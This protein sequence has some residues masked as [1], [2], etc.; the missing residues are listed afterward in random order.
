M[1][2]GYSGERTPTLKTLQA[3]H[4]HHAESIPFENLNPFLGLPVNLDL[5]SL[6]QK[7]VRSGRGGYCYEQNLLLSHVLNTLGFKV[8]GLAARG[9][10]LCVVTTS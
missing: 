6:Q 1:R 4:I 9:V 3:I 5:E 7:L 2:V 8:T 10:G